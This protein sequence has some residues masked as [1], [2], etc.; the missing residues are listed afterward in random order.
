MSAARIHHDVEPGATDLFLIFLFTPVLGGEL[1]LKVKSWRD[2]EAL[3]AGIGNRK[4]FQI[5]TKRL[6]CM[7]R[8]FLHDHQ[9]ERI[10]QIFAYFS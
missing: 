3:M 2:C 1:F 9:I 5:I 8:G 4:W 6:V 10:A 7:M